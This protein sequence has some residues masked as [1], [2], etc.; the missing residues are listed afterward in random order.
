MLSQDLI[1]PEECDHIVSIASPI[2]KP[3]TVAR[4]GNK[5]TYDVDD[6]VRTSSTACGI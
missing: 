6:Q 4:M 2:M 3:S 5:D 1:A